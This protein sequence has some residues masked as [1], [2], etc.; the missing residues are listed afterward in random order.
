MSEIQFIIILIVGLAILLALL[1]IGLFCR[2]KPCVL[3]RSVWPWAA[4]LF[5]D[6]Q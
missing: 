5:G 1:F 3:L 4:N 2:D 6:K